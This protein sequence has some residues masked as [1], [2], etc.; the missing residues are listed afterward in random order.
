MTGDALARIG[1]LRILPVVVIEDAA[2]AAPL[3]EALLR[4]GLPLVEVTLRTPGAERALAELAGIDGMLVGAGTVLTSDQVDRAV[5]AGAA[6]IVS[7]GLDER[8]VARAVARDIAVVPGVATATEIQRAIVLGISIVKLFPAGTLGGPAAVAALAAPFPG[9]R[10]IPTGGVGPDDIDGYLAQP[11][12]LA[13]GGSWM[14]TPTLLRASRWDEISTLARDA[15]ARA[16][17]AAGSS[18]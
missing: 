1:Q 18:G 14:V 2:A 15:R 5:D 9:L 10:F 16:E 3:G 4:A 8:V 6:F 7:P 12:V 17:A 13:V 11:A